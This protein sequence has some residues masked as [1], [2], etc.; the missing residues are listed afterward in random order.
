MV[1]FVNSGGLIKVKGF[2]KNKYFLSFVIKTKE[3]N[4]NQLKLE[5]RFNPIFYF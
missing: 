5:I 3:K 1:A 2:F 4:P